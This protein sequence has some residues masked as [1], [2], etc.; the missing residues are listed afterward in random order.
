VGA[1]GVDAVLEGVGSL[2]G[3]DVEQP[4]ARSAE[5]ARSTPSRMAPNLR[6]DGTRI[7]AMGDARARRYVTRARSLVQGSSGRQRLGAGAAAVLLVTAPFGGLRATAPTDPDPITAKESFRVGP[8]DVVVDHVV[9]VSDLK[10]QIEPETEGNRLLAVVGT[11]R[12]PGVR[13]EYAVLL[14]RAL[15][16][17]HGDVV[18]PAGG[19]SASQLVSLA[20]GEAISEVNPGLTYKVAFVFEQ[21]AGW[22]KQ[23]VT[24]DVL[25]YTF[26]EE[27]PLT[28]DPNSWLRGDDVAQRGDFPV[29][30][31]P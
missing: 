15:S 5:T 1:A 22:K 4:V 16:V 17:R 23:D 29:K 21:R 3:V 9:T 2:R 14:T 30:V 27:D 13:P 18:A 28:L 8:F 12:N 26:Q 19:R 6:P 25:G 7:P 24:V 31:N 20:D 11:V 10:P